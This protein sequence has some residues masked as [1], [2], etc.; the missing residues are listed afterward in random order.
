MCVTIS[1]I[2]SMWP[3]TSS[4]RRALS[5]PCLGATQRQRRADHVGAHLGE[6]ARRLAPHLG[7]G[8][9]HSRTA[10]A[11]RA[12][13]AGPAAR[14]PRPARSPAGVSAGSLIA[15]AALAGRTGGCRRGGS[16]PPRAAC[17]CARARR[18]C[19]DRSEI[20]SPPSRSALT[21][22]SRGGP[23][24]PAIASARPVIEKISSPVSP[25]DCALWPVGELQRQHAHADQ[26][27]AVD[28]LEALRDHRPHAEQLRALGGPVARGARAVLP[29]REHDQLDALAHVAHGGVVDRHLLRV[30]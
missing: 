8:A 17:R 30:A 28:A 23:P 5:K 2:S 10:R 27:R 9:S 20:G 12:G 18:S 29:A 16:T 22:T 7:R 6:R 14:R 26:V 4:R 11:R 3:I 13:R 19:T 25:S 15:R 1:P 24:P 21:C